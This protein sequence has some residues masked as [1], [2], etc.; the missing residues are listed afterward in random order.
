VTF[1]IIQGKSRRRNPPS[2]P[3]SCSRVQKSFLFL[4]YYTRLLP[5]LL[6]LLRLRSKTI[7]QHQPLGHYTI[8][9]T[10][11]YHPTREIG[12]EERSRERLRKRRN[13]L[14]VDGPC[15][16]MVVGVTQRERQHHSL[17]YDA[18]T[19]TT[20]CATCYRFT[21]TGWPPSAVPLDAIQQPS[22]AQPTPNFSISSKTQRE[23]GTG[24]GC[25]RVV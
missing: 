14:Q 6:L 5:P 20:T 25:C 4:V 15:M 10:A 24:T 1:E 17:L 12:R 19:T 13:T 7:Q 16:L 18:T 3:Y 11:R 23:K 8:T 21:E 2:V 9:T 22:P